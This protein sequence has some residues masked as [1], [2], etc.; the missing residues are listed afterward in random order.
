ME[1]FKSQIILPSKISTANF[2]H[3]L[4]DNSKANCQAQ[5]QVQVRWRSGEAQESQEGQI[6]GP[7]LYPIFGFL[8]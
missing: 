5:V 4:F 2:N 1:Q 7:E 8:I 3:H 6:P